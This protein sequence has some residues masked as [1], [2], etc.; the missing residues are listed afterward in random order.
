MLAGYWVIYSDKQQIC[1]TDSYTSLGS[2]KINIE[3][4]VILV[5]G[6]AIEVNKE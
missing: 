5:K 4:I 6:G 3:T 2:S 1:S